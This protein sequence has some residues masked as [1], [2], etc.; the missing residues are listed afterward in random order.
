MPYDVVSHLGLQSCNDKM[1]MTSLVM[2]IDY[3]GL[4]VATSFFMRSEREKS[5]AITNRVPVIK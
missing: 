1:H 4:V 2:I 5:T 3:R